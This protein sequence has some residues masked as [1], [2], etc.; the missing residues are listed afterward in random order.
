MNKLYDELSGIPNNNRD[1]GVFLYGL[2]F[3]TR[4]KVVVELGT[5]HGYTAICMAKAMQF[6]HKKKGEKYNPL[7]ITIDNYKHCRFITTEAN[8]ILHDV[9]N[10]IY[11]IC[12]DTTKMDNFRHDDPINLLFMDACHTYEG[13]EREYSVW[14]PH[15]APDALVLI[16]DYHHPNG[17]VAAWVQEFAVRENQAYTLLDTTDGLGLVMIR[18]RNGK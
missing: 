15:L 6:W 9:A 2:V 11:A 10:Y 8:F 3:T 18:M 14:F 17:E 1:L 13:L 7:L 4:P 12:A 5:W 16:H